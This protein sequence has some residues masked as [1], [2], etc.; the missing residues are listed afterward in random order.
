V[1]LGSLRNLKLKVQNGVNL[2]F[3]LHQKESL[4]T[5]P[6]VQ[7]SGAG[8]AE[9]ASQMVSSPAETTNTTTE[10][11]NPLILKSPADSVEEDLSQ[12]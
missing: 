10:P 11:S 2:S 8:P 5:A 3:I 1:E 12:S 9:P 4:R 6:E 7:E